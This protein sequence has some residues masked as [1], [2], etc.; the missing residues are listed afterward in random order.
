MR[1]LASLV[2]LP[3]LAV[4]L[5][6]A[7]DAQIAGL[8]RQ[9]GSDD[10]AEREEAAKKLVE[11]GE[12]ALPAL[13]KASADHPDVEVRKS[14][15]A[16]RDR[17]V[18]SLFGLVRTFS[19]HA[20]QVNCVAVTPDGKH[21][22]T[23]GLDATLRLWDTATGKEV[24]QLQEGAGGVW[25]VAVSADGRYALSSLG[26]YENGGRWVR[27][28]DHAVRLWDLTARK[29]VRTFRGHTDELRGLAFSSDGKYALSG[30]LDG[31]AR[32]WEVETGKEVR[33]F[34]GHTGALRRVA[35]S[36]DGKRAVTSSLDGTARA[37]DVATG[38]EISRFAG[39]NADVL[40]AAFLP[41]SRHAVSG[42]AD[43]V[44]RLW[45]VETGKE[46]R[47]FEG[48][49]SVIFNLAVSP[50]GRR[51]LSASG[52]REVNRGSYAPCGE[53][54]E[55]RLWD[56]ATGAE[57][58]RYAGHGSSVVGVRFGPDG[59]TAFTCGSDRTLRMWKVSAAPR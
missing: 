3:C 5:T 27:G 44:V 51:L 53:D 45:D 24:W 59:R 20:G 55:V 35:L 9:L 13:R 21:A 46:V 47:R 32:L 14:A 23:G 37:W 56:V 43:M 31:T 12:P 33:R 52:M 17:I 48:H 11:L 28:T 1:R 42:G 2:L 6:A 10:F 58:H 49:T 54:N 57:L 39:H 16:A 4:P 15:A 38:K 29:Q 22:L 25:C 8:I 18:D 34:E 7:D 26:M 30:S 50:D 41:D 40:V 36:P 19:G